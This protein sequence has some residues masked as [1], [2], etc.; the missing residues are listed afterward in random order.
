M[1]KTDSRGQV[2]TLERV[3]NGIPRAIFMEQAATLDVDSI[4]TTGETFKEPARIL[5]RAGNMK[6]IDSMPA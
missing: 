2:K 6:R 4:K 5:A 3:G 1:A